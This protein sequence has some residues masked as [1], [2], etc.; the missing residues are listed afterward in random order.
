LPKPENGKYSPKFFF[1]SSNSLEEEQVTAAELAMT[2]HGIQHN[3][4]Y[5]SQDCGNKLFCK[6]FSDSK[7]SKKICCGRTKAEV[8]TENILSHHS[9]ELTL[10]ELQPNK[11]FS[12]STDASNK[13][14]LKLYPV[15]VRF[16]STTKGVIDRLIDFYEDSDESA[17]G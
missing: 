13:G 15:S 11:P 10:T 3:Y 8:F 6:I 14:N 1:T 16:F 4:N 7:L 2:F 17:D 5:S 12:L 9:V